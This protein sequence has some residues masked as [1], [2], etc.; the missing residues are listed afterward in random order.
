MTPR[1]THSW[2]HEQREEE[3]KRA[4]VAPISARAS[5]LPG[6]TEDDELSLRAPTARHRSPSPALRHRDL[7]PAALGPPLR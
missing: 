3:A 5:L 2:L 7:S 4:L 1:P 6:Q